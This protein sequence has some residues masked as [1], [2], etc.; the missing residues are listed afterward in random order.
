MA[1]ILEAVIAPVAVG[2]AET[3]A[4]SAPVVA[5]LVA[6]TAAV[7]TPALMEAVAVAGT[8]TE[9]ITAGTDV[10]ASSLAATE[11]AS[12]T[13]NILKT[14]SET[15][16][17]ATKNAISE[18]KI[19]SP[20]PSIEN[21][22]NAA[23]N[24]FALRVNGIVKDIEIGKLS[25]EDGMKQLRDAP[26][27]QTGNETVSQTSE[28]II[29]EEFAQKA[30]DARNIVNELRNVQD[31]NHII[32][33]K[34]ETQTE[35]SDVQKA[36]L[37]KYN[38][39]TLTEWS[40]TNPMPDAKD[41]EA[42]DKWTNERMQIERKA[43]IDFH[44]QQW[45]KD[46]PPPADQNSKEFSEW[47]NKRE[48]Q[49]EKARLERDEKEEQKKIEEMSPV[50]ITQK[51]KELLE[52]KQISEDLKDGIKALRETKPTKETDVKKADFVVTKIQV[53]TQAKVIEKQ[54]K[55]AALLTNNPITKTAINV[56]L[57]A[58]A[59]ASVAVAVASDIKK[60]AQPV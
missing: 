42:F 48:R 56:A 46:N 2:I 35:M 16:A 47:I 11:S 57:A 23:N 45:Q 15:I 60:D 25:P 52:L 55:I 30:A 40:K 36:E 43:E 22:V 4:A 17:N 41:S 26:L 39:E 18:T 59:T 33:N 13:G 14:T 37:E 28:T 8:A 34:I 24:S 6:E 51:T 7:T 44:V 9:G 3:A 32:D 50:E 54:L 21:A 38:R 29:P 1:P 12:T 49:K 19:P 5:P 53:D 58:A 27:P 10:V 31:E 20:T